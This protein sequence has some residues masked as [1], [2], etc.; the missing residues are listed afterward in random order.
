MIGEENFLLSAFTT[1]R[2]VKSKLPT[3]TLPAATVTVVRK[4]VTLT[5]FCKRS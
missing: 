4:D 2:A 5:K 3:T 1:N